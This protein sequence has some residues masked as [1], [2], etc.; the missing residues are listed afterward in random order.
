LIFTP[1]LILPHPF[2]R[3]RTGKGEETVWN[4]PNSFDPD[5]H[6]GSGQAGQMGEEIPR[7]VRGELRFIE[8]L[9]IPTMM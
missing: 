7:L 2:D 6:R 5:A 9:A 3:L 1:S 8:H 4:T